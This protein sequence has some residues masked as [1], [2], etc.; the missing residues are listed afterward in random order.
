MAPLIAFVLWEKKGKFIFLLCFDSL[1]VACSF[2]CDGGSVAANDWFP[3]L[4]HVRIG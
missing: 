4:T 1:P 2:W 3:I